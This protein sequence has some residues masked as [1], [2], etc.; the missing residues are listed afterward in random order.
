M[1]KQIKHKLHFGK[2][3]VQ[4]LTINLD[5]CLLL[6]VCLFIMEADSYSNEQK[7]DVLKCYILCQRKCVIAENMNSNT[8]PYIHLVGIR[9]IS[10]RVV[11]KNTSAD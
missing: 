2:L 7:F 9:E 5:F 8:Y 11:E 6:V 3:L 1:L 10:M 4:H